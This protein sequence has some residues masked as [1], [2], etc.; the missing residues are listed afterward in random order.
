MPFKQ[1]MEWD[2]AGSS[3]AAIERGQSPVER[4]CVPACRFSRHWY[5]DDEYPCVKLH[6]QLLIVSSSL[7]L[8]PWTVLLFVSELDRNLQRNQVA[9]SDR[10]LGT[11]SEL[12]ASRENAWRALRVRAVSKSLLAL[13]SPN[14]VLLDGYAHDWAGYELRAREFRFRDNKVVYERVDREA[15]SRF[16]ILAAVHEDRLNLFLRVADDRLIYHNPASRTIATGDRILLRVPDDEG[17]IRRYT[18]SA[19]G[20]GRIVA[21]YRGA[22]FEGVRPVLE[23]PDYRAALL[24]TG[25]G[26]NLEMSIPLPVDGRFGVVVEDVDQSD[27]VV[28]WTGMFD[29]AVV[30]DTG[31]LRVLEDDFNRL[32]DNHT[33]A[34][35]RIRVFDAQGWIVADSDRRMPDSSVRQ[36]SPGSA[37]ILDAVLFRFISTALTKSVDPD[38][39]PAFTSGRMSTGDTESVVQMAGRSR[40][41]RDRYSRVFLVGA[42]K[43]ESADGDL[44]GY[45]LLQRPRAA[46]TAL[47]ERSVLRLIKIFGASVLL[48]AAALIGFSLFMSWRIRHL[49]N[50]VEA[51]VSDEGKVQR[52]A[53]ASSVRDEIGDLSRSFHDMSRRQMGYT[54]Y[55]QTLGSKLS[56][57]LRTP[58]SVLTTSLEGID[59]DLLDERSRRCVVRA[60]E[61]ATRLQKLIRNLS[62]ASSLEQ[63]ISRADKDRIDMSAWLATALDIYR[64]IYPQQLFELTP[65][66]AEQTLQI[67]GSVELLQQMMD[68]LVSNA[69]D[70]SAAD[71]PVRLGL[72]SDAQSVQL[73]VLNYGS[74]LPAGLEENVFESM[75]S[76]REVRDDQPHMG[77]GLFI[78]RLIAEFHGAQC[79]ARNVDLPDGQAV[80]FTIAFP[81]A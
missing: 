48:I 26:Y 49:R 23:D 32:L 46:M 59:R 7:L 22:A 41:L 9:A 39:F 81:R 12:L 31:Q 76:H 45:V 55:L 27:G 75:V 63:T 64:D 11:I 65:L 72:K 50:E 43:V 60:D 13:Q 10:Q 74:R 57:E 73:M 1:R 56:H 36:F 6:W 29:P 53:R 25:A 80:A 40:F 5:I 4:A 16:S 38:P 62:E 24:E 79:H 18:F 28:R 21:R 8:L 15:A 17:N 37:S 35:M 3:R 44:F 58:L 47:T 68:K 70:F 69:C 71:R 30:D 54:D 66:A 77:L 78:V 51:V 2:I 61:G 14:D 20:A 67:D 19:E 42:S 34:G 52:L 33:E